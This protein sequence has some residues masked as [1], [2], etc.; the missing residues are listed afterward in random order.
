MAARFSKLRDLDRE[1]FAKFMAQTTASK[2]YVM[3]FTPRSGSSW[4]TDLVTSVR[5]LG[6]P[7]ECF[8]PNFMPV[9]TR[10]MNA[11]NLD[12]YI[13]VLP[14][15][16]K[17]R[18]V[19]GFQITHHQL[20]KVFRSHNAFAS[21]FP[22]DVW[23]SFWLIREDI[24]AQAVS[25][26]KMINT[27]I[28]HTK[29]SDHDEI[30]QRDLEISYNGAEIKTWLLHILEAER[31]TEQYF[32]ETGTTPFR[33]SYERNFAVPPRRVLNLMANHV[34]TKKF[35]HPP[36]NQHK[37][38]ATQLNEEFAAKFRA[39]HSDFVAEIEAERAP[40]IA[41]IGNYLMPGQRHRV[42]TGSGWTR[43]FDK[44]QG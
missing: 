8:N 20:I 32:A 37:K 30:M 25:L 7:D 40:M 26:Y 11:K 34:G 19:F 4:I 28:A 41:S 42:W 12:E 17:T 29:H 39:D 1:E 5:F 3:H 22:P 33:M 31:G 9:M 44:V 24:V 6:R 36:E 10:R 13:E 16:R 18:D 23:H 21:Y 35:N 14:R 38:I 43:K 2:R 27:Q 15:R